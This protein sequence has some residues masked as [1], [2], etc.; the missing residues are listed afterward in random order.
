MRVLFSWIGFRDL[1]FIA[2]EI[3]KEKFSDAL[4]AAKKSSSDSGG[5]I[6]N[7]AEFSPIVKILNHNLNQKTS[8]ER[9]ILFCDLKDT[10][11][12]NGVKNISNAT[13]RMLK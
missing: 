8:F 1:N 9:L 5:N 3:K 4:K 10:I 6:S 11:L 2:N 13:L 12:H 7:S